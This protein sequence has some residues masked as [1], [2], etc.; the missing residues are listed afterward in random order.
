MAQ[1]DWER[2][3]LPEDREIYALSG[4]GRRVGFGS[5]PA[6]LIIDVQYRTVGDT[7]APIREAIQTMYPTACGQV[8][9][10]AVAN[11]AR[12]LEAARPAGVPVIYPYVAP[13]KQ[14][15]AGVFGQINPMITSI[16]E[17]GYE[18]VAEIAPLEDDIL[19]PKRH[20]SAFFGTALESYL[21][22]LRIDTLLVTGCTTS[23]CVRATVCDAFSYNYHT[24]VVEECVYD[25]IETSHLVSLFDMDAKYAD[26][27]SVDNAISYVQQ[28]E[29]PLRVDG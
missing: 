25:R 26:V 3:I 7:P 9:W 4:F 11:I 13:K 27:V 2:V 16:P 10:N 22:D 29:Q 15:D 24:I 17:K 8:G 6:I 20:A 14:I 19:I 12:L 18:F 1:E 21:N 28:L 5:N 23:G